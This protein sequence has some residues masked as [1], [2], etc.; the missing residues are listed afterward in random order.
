MVFY[1]SKRR[2]LNNDQA[3]QQRDENE[4]ERTETVGA[5]QSQLAVVWVPRPTPQPR[6]AHWFGIGI[7][8][9]IFA[10]FERT[11]GGRGCTHDVTRKTAHVSI[12]LRRL[13][14]TERALNALFVLFRRCPAAWTPAQGVPLHIQA[15]G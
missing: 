6:I 12:Q 10:C 14:R 3:T 9:A 1:L 13:L 15:G 2:R 4:R 7:F 8:V 5:R 11:L